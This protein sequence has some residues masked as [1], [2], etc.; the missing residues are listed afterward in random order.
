MNM[1]LNS[2]KEIRE[3]YMNESLEYSEN[4][5][6]YEFFSNKYD[7]P[8]NEGIFNS[9]VNWFRKNFSPTARKIQN[10]GIEYYNWLTSEYEA[11]YKGGEDDESELSKFLKSE[12]ISSDIEQ[13]INDVAGDVEAYKELARKTIAKYKIKAKKDFSNSLLGPKSYVTQEFDKSYTI[14]D[15]DLRAQQ[16]EMTAE[17]S[18]TFKKL[19]GEVENKIKSQGNQRDVSRLLALG[20]MQFFQTRLTERKMKY[21]LNEIMSEFDKGE[22]SVMASNKFFKTYKGAQMLYAARIFWHDWYN[23]DMKRED[24]GMTL[25]GAKLAEWINKSIQN[26]KDVGIKDPMTLWGFTLLYISQRNA[27]EASDTLNLIQNIV[28]GK[29]EDELLKISEE[30]EK[31]VNDVLKNSNTVESQN[32]MIDKLEK[33]VEAE[34]KSNNTKEEDKKEREEFDEK[35]FPKAFKLIKEL[36]DNQ[37]KEAAFSIVLFALK[38]L[39]TAKIKGKYVRLSDFYKKDPKYTNSKTGIMTAFST[40]GNN[41]KYDGELMTPEILAELRK[42]YGLEINN[43][44]EMK[45]NQNAKKAAESLLTDITNCIKL[46]KDQIEKSEDNR[47]SYI[48]TQRFVTTMF[49]AKKNFSKEPVTSEEELRKKYEDLFNEEIFSKN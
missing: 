12:K 42:E 35:N 14:A 31:K 19:V 41:L 5:R 20:L 26:L 39:A 16:E 3:K 34:E 25:P 33:N 46:F 47:I 18:K 10:L 17:Q 48:K 49:I 6:L 28:E 29:S 36:D 1:N 9:V 27:K 24:G 23:K 45:Y 11:T 22:D 4:P 32:L 40:D 44:G 7:I 43:K 30:L 37:T 8:L 38:S 13:Q 2:F 15:K 21:S